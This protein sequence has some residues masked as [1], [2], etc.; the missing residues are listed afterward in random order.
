MEGEDGLFLE[1]GGRDGRGV[2]WVCGVRA[3][4]EVWDCD[5]ELGSEEQGEVKEACP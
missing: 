1:V 2:G 4:R 5:G 3:G